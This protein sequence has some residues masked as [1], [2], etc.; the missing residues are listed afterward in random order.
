MTD[1][2]EAAAKARA[3]EQLSAAMS[4]I[5]M[6]GNIEA[7]AEARARREEKRIADEAAARQVCCKVAL[8]AELSTE[9]AGTGRTAD[10]P[11][12]AQILVCS[13]VSGCA[14]GGSQSAPPHIL[15]GLK[16]MHPP[17]VHRALR[18]RPLSAVSAERDRS[19]PEL[20]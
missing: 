14:C 6:Q 1:T 13:W 16:G 3:E 20:I 9:P 18:Q 12:G 7:E 10:L 4:A 11:G 5:A 17:S 2:S 19:R 15:L 8:A